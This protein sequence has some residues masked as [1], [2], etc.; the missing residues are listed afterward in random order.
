MRDIR[1]SVANQLS[2]SVFEIGQTHTHVQRSLASRGSCVKISPTTQ[3]PPSTVTRVNIVAHKLVSANLWA[4]TFSILSLFFPSM[5]MALYDRA[6]YGRSC[7]QTS[8]HLYLTPSTSSHSRRLFSHDE[9]DVFA[10]QKP[11]APREQLPHG[12]RG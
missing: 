9:G 12:P 11:R 8:L 10:R 7:P 4:T 5:D 6:V 1:S 2:K 3:R